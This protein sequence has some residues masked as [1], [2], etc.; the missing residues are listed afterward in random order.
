M[1]IPKRYLFTLLL[2]TFFYGNNIAQGQIQ[3]IKR[4]Q[5]I[6]V[7]AEYAYWVTSM[8]E[9]GCTNIDLG[10]YKLTKA[11]KDIPQYK[12]GMVVWAKGN[13]V[14][15][16]D[17]PTIAGPRANTSMRGQKVVMRKIDVKEHQEVNFVQV[18]MSEKA[19]AKLAN[20]EDF[21]VDFT[22]KN[23]L[24]KPIKFKFTFDN[25]TTK[26]S[27]GV[28]EQKTLS[29]DVPNNKSR[30]YLSYRIVNENFVLKKYAASLKVAERSGL[31]IYLNGSIYP[32]RL[33][34]K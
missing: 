34:K 24:K 12:R 6:Q 10:P 30:S 17:L 5:P 32:T 22:F 9:Q 21:A 28:A 20:N 31:I 25:K 14:L 19:K 8:C 33:A 13:F 29:F 15:V 1:M 23:P 18:T 2:L 27:L 16:K 3:I 26:V 4:Q 11:L 7:I